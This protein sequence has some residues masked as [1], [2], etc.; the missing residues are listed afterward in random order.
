MILKRRVFVSLLLYVDKVIDIHIYISPYIHTFYMYTQIH[1]YYRVALVKLL[2]QDV[3]RI[4]LVLTD[5][6]GSLQCGRQ[7]CGGC[8]QIC[9]RQICGGCRVRSTSVAAS[10]TYKHDS[11]HQHTLSLPAHNKPHQTVGAF[12]SLS[13]PRTTQLVTH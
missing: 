1:I 3:A 13:P 8:R 4:I 11:R 7:I 9:G 10:T 6:G 12:M 5:W 2:S